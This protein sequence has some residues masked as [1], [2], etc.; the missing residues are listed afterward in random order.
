[1]EHEGKQPHQL[2]WWRQTDNKTCIINSHTWTAVVKVHPWCSHELLTYHDSQLTLPSHQT[3]GWLQVDTCCSLKTLCLFTP[4]QFFFAPLQNYAVHNMQQLSAIASYLDRMVFLSIFSTFFGN[5][6]CTFNYITKLSM[7]VVKH[8]LEL[9]EL[10]VMGYGL[11][12]P[13]DSA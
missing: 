2:K 3:I 13:G 9:F 5:P 7:V 11:K 6:K 4:L 10:P 12:Y 8:R 1:M